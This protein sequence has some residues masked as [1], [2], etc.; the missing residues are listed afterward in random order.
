MWDIV[1]FVRGIK[2]K[3]EPEGLRIMRDS[4]QIVFAHCDC[5]FVTRDHQIALGLLKFA[6]HGST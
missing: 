5:L 1:F 2:K 4:L 6:A 3:G